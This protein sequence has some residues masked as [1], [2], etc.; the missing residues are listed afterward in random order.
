M[1]K[2]GSAQLCTT[3][4]LWTQ[5]VGLSSEPVPLDIVMMVSKKWSGFLSAQFSAEFG[6]EFG[7]DFG[8]EFGAKS[9]G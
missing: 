2:V 3:V 1:L 6:I 7:V 9:G 5:I 4:R 8:A